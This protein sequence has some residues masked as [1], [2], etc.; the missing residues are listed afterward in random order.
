MH[1][2]RLQIIF[3]LVPL[4]TKQITQKYCVKRDV[5][6]NSPLRELC[7]GEKK[8]LS[9]MVSSL[10]GP[11]VILDFAVIKPESCFPSFHLHVFIMHSVMLIN[12]TIATVRTP[13]G[14]ISAHFPNNNNAFSGFQKI[15][16]PA[17]TPFPISCVTVYGV[18]AKYVVFLEKLE[19]LH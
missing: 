15:H 16:L 7:R 12:W 2:T 13:E 8:E 1:S 10:R 4:H 5:Q 17:T 3:S 9:S 6:N 18:S 11:F 19:D 14:R